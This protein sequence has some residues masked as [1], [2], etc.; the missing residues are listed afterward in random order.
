MEA[1]RPPPQKQS[2]SRSWGERHAHQL[3]A[4]GAALIA[5][6]ACWRFTQPQLLAALVLGWGLLALGIID[7]RSQLLPDALTLP[8]L[9]LGL[10]VNHW[11]LFAPLPDALWGAMAGYLVPR[12]VYHVHHACTGYPGLGLGDCKLLAASGAWLGW[13]ALPLML[14]ASSV[15]GLVSAWVGGAKRRQPLPFGPHLAASCWMLLL[16]PELPAMHPPG[17]LPAP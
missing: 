11:E 8:L 14:L 13:Q 4:V 3:V 15:S 2:A 17:G 5:A 16:W 1:L 6:T 12:L 10:A 9:W 7:F